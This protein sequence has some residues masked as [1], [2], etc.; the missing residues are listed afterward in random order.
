M[1]YLPLHLYLEEVKKLP[2]KSDS[3][4][5]EKI[6]EFQIVKR[7]GQTSG[8]SVF[9]LDVDYQNF[10]IF[11]C[12]DWSWTKLTK[13]LKVVIN[14][15]YSMRK[16]IQPGIIKWSCFFKE[17]Q[18]ERCKKDYEKLSCLNSQQSG[19]RKDILQHNKSI[20]DKPTANIILNSEKLKAFPL[21]SGT[22][23]GSPLSPV[24]L[25]IVLKVITTALDKKKI[26]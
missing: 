13:I 16:W 23:Q 4:I 12:Q 20:H 17:N 1:D 2:H 24:L 9:H 5:R 22:R 6:C 8:A 10:H 7:R 14:L 15:V 21:R 11:L 25:N 18:D 3:W 26:K 19:Y